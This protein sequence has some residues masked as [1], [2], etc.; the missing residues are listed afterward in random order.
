M[1][2]NIIK[3]V[4]GFLLTV[5]EKYTPLN[6]KSDSIDDT[7]NYLQIHENLATSGQPTEKQFS[8][9]AEA[10]YRVVINLAPAS[11]LENSLHTE[12]SLLESLGIRYIHIP[13]NF[14]NP[15]EN[16]FDQFVNSLESA[17]EEKVWV[18]CAANA[19]VSAFMYRYRLSVLGED[20]QIAK[21]DLHKIWEP[22]GVWRKFVS[23]NR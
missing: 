4:W 6:L 17:T 11:V 13:V 1:K 2:T 15:T 16:D 19:R 21:Q 5:V 23:S 10:G 12:A 18:H 7:F 3:T 8:L 9:I 20:E 22:F 14:T